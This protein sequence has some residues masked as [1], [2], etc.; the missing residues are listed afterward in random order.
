MRRARKVLSI[1]LTVSLLLG[2]SLAQAETQER[3]FGSWCD[4][5][6]YRI[7]IGPQGIRFRDRQMGDPP[8]GTDLVVK[9]GT[10]TYTQDFRQS[11]WPQIGLLSCTL[12]LL[13]DNAA[14][15]TCSGDGYGFMPFFALK[16]CPQDVIS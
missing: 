16:R 12:R 15:E 7:D 3:L 13:G 8:A 1:L 11:A 5:T 4:D 9:D 14:A 2:T 10:A 6:G